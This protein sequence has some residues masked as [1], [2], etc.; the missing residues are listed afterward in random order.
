MIVWAWLKNKKPIDLSLKKRQEGSVTLAYGKQLDI[1]YLNKVAGEV[2]A[3]SN[4]TNTIGD[5]V[6]RLLESYAVDREELKSDI[7]DLI[8]DLQWKRLIRLED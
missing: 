8:R 7:V 6:E 4:G 1:C 2:L 3:L 5:I